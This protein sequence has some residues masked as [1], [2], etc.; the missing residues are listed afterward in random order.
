M[1]Y[2]MS[3]TKPWYITLILVYGFTVAIFQN[4]GISQW[5]WKGMQSVTNVCLSKYSIKASKF[6]IKK[7]NVNIA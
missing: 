1:L 7:N 4:Y 5:E 6:E 2:A 3:Q